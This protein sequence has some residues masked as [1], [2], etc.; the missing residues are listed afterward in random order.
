MRDFHVLLHSGSDTEGYYASALLVSSDLSLLGEP[1]YGGSFSKLM[2]LFFYLVGP[3]R[4]FAQYTN[5]LMGVT[6]LLIAYKLL[7]EQLELKKSIVNKLMVLGAVMPNWAILSSLFLRESLIALLITVSVAYF[8]A[9]LLNGTFSRFFLAVTFALMATVFHSGM[10]AVAFGYILVASVYQ[11][12]HRKFRVGASTLGY[13]FLLVP[14]VVFVVWKYPELFLGKFSSLESAEDL[15]ATVNSTRGGSAYLTSMNA[16]NVGQLI[17]FAPVRALYFLAAPMPWDW[18]GLNDA[19]MAFSDSSF[20]VGAFYFA[21]KNR[22]LAGGNR[23][24]IA[25]LIVVILV[26]SM[27][28]GVG[29]SNTGTALRHRYK[30]SSFFLVVYALAFERRRRR[31]ATLA[32]S[33]G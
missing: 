23:T 29:V 10:I 8:V 33:C 17:A 14:A 3:L 7:A 21:F 26:V 6:V 32:S 15:I 31:D 22:H 24:L 20:Y 18:R 13:L 25:S 4:S 2:G 30:V 12:R 11:R 5:A 19:F 1:V 16:E 28:F 9:W 27:L